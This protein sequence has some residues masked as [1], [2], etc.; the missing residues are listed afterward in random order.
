MLTCTCARCECRPMDED[1]FDVTGRH[2]PWLDNK[3]KKRYMKGCY[4]PGCDDLLLEG[5]IV[6]N[7]N[8]W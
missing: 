8:N 4:C 5:S 6:K 1:A 7:R 2:H 3:T